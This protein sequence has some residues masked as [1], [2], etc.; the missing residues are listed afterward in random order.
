M[1]VSIKANLINLA[2]TPQEKVEMI[3]LP[4]GEGGI[5]DGN[6][7]TSGPVYAFS[8]TSGVATA[9]V[10]ADV[11]VRAKVPKANFDKYFKTPSSG[12]LD[13]STL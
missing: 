5:V 13:L 2:A 3:I 11:Q 8:N 6:L 10:A 9:T 4:S 12:T 7:I 1:S